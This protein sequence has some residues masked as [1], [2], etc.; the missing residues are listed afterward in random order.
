MVGGE[1]TDFDDFFVYMERCVVMFF[2]MNF[3]VRYSKSW[4][5]ISNL[6]GTKFSRLK[7]YIF[8]FSPGIRHPD[9]QPYLLMFGVL[10]RF[11]YD[12]LGRNTFS[13][14]V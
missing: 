1:E 2:N 9:I 6:A 7:G 5:G 14:N 8:S 11:S 12:C 3:K 4:A 10:G 13:E